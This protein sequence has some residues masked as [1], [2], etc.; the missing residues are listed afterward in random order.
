[1]KTTPTKP[2]ESALF[3]VRGARFKAPL[4]LA[5]L[6]TSAGSTLAQPL[7]TGPPA[8]VAVLLGSNATFRV[9]AVGA[10]LSYQWRSEAGDLLGATN[11]SLVVNNVSLADLGSYT[12][13]VSN[14]SGQTVSPPAW[15]KLARWTQM[16]V[17]GDSEC[18]AQ[19]SNGRAWVDWLGQYL[20]LSAPGQIKNYAVGGAGTLAV[21]SQ[22]TEYLRANQP[23]TNTIIATTW[24][25]ISGDLA[26]N[27]TPVSQVISNYASNLFLLAQAG[28][29][30]FILPTVPPLYLAPYFSS[31]AYLRGLDY[32]DLNARM[33]AEIRKLATNF[34]GF[35]AFWLDWSNQWAQVWSDPPAYGF[36]NVTDA[37]NA[38][39]QCDAN[40]YVFWDGVHP[41]TTF[42]RWIAQ[43]AYPVLA[44][45]L[46]VVAP[47]PAASGALA[48]HWRGGNPPYQVQHT[49]DLR[50]GLWQSE[51]LTFST[52]ATLTPSP[53]REFVRIL[54]LGQ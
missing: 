17:V 35:T 1:M 4:L 46:E 53:Q 49:E 11:A 22:I 54:Y 34:A 28:G 40:R 45:P 7:I 43:Q 21:R 10:A 24:A 20:C 12:V 30:A 6:W 38:C 47:T 9:T 42:H 39:I 33:D 44:P 32:S 2:S 29:R 18:M 13:V 5:L 51:S 23:G 36:T 15:L 50:S 3:N 27:H 52:N 37:A 8:S 48:L 41:T 31:D 25:G 19:Y 16:V 14:A 26:N